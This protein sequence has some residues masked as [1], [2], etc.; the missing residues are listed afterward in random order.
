[1]NKLLVTAIMATCLFFLAT[2]ACPADEQLSSTVNA[3]VDNIFSMEWE[4]NGTYVTYPNGGPINFSNVSPA[5]DL[6]YADGHTT[7]HPDIALI[8]KNNE[9]P[10]W[11]IKTSVSGDLAGNLLYYLPKPTVDGVATTGTVVGGTPGSGDPWPVISNNATIYKSGDD[12]VNT[13]FGSYCG[14]SIGVNG[15]G[16]SPKAQGVSISGTITFTMTQS[17]L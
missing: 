4:T 10:Q 5:S 13:P 16:L 3:T 11:G 14:M 17:S 8:C 9:T 12:N 7:Q 6:N 15:G 2:I 1:M